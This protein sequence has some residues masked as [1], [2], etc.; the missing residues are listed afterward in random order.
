MKKTAIFITILFAAT[1]IHSYAQGC[2]EPSSDEGVSVIGYLQPEYQLHETTEGWTNSFAFRR[3]R[4]GVTGNIPY[5]FSYYAMVDFSRFMPDSPYLLDAFVSYNRFPFAHITLGQYKPPFTQELQTACHKLHTINRSKVVDEL[6]LPNRDQGLMVWGKFASDIVS[7]NVALMNDFRRGYYDENNNKSVVGRVV[8]QP[9]DAFRFGG[10]FRRGITGKES[11]NMNTKTR[12]AGEMQVDWKGF[13]LQAEYVW[14]EDTGSY[15][16][17]GG[18][19]GSPI[20]I[21]EGPITRSGMYAM[22]L[23]MTPWNLQPVVKFETYNDDLSKANNLQTITTFG[24][25]YFF[26]DWTRVQINYAYRAEQAEEIPNDC[27]LVQVQVSF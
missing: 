2:M 11:D 8:I 24:F 7:Y 13:L 3:A 17:G 26:N 6:A 23:Y 14:G 25:N 18:C 27:L 1:G 22:L 5:D 19:D 12:F 21:H 10:S 4:L 16:T 9:W 15:T 20:E